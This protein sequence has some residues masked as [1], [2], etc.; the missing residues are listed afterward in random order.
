MDLKTSEQ[1]VTGSVLRP[2]LADL[3][4][5]MFSDRYHLAATTLARVCLPLNGG[6]HAMDNVFQLLQ[7]VSFVVAVECPS[8]GGNRI[9]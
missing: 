4:K 3:Q 7:D 5:F 6:P 2:G 9:L 8:E 1:N